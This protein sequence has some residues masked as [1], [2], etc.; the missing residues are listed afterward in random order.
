[1]PSAWALQAISSIASIAAAATIAFIPPPPEGDESVRETP[2]RCQT[3]RRAQGISDTIPPA[4]RG[5]A[6]DLACRGGLC[7]CAWG[8]RPWSSRKAALF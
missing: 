3:G 1:M 4:G 5:S 8:L 7:C 6:R 2:N